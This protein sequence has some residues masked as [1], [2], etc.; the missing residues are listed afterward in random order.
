VALAIEPLA[1]VRGEAYWDRVQHIGGASDAQCSHY[2][3]EVVVS[4][5]GQ[6]PLWLGHGFDQQKLFARFS[7]CHFLFG[8][9]GSLAFM[10]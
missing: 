6:A 8:Q 10:R 2:D 9:I 5:A 7:R 3:S 4:A 1:Q